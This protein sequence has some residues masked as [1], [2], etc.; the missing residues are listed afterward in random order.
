[1]RFRGA[2]LLALSL[3]SAGCSLHEVREEYPTGVDLP[4]SY[5]IRGDG[6]LSSGPWW[7]A[8]GD[9]RLSRTVTR[10][11]DGNPGLMQSWSRLRQ[12]EAIALQAESFLYPEITAR[13]GASRSRTS[14]ALGG[15]AGERDVTTSLFSLSAGVAYEVDLWKRL[16][17][18]RDAAATLALASREDVDALAMTLASQ[19]AET[20]FSIAEQKAQIDL[21]EEQQRIGLTFLELLELRFSLGQATALDVYQ[22]RQQVAATRAQFPLAESRLGVLRNQLA[23][24][25]GLAPGSLEDEP[26][27]ILPELPAVPD[28]GLPAEL[29]QRRPDVRGA[30]LRILAADHGVGEAVADLLPALRLSAEVGVQGRVLE[31]TFSNMIYQ[32][33]AGL[34]G[35]VYDRGRRRAEVERRKEILEE[36]LQGYR[37]K[38][39][40]ALGEVEDALVREDRQ[41]AYLLELAKQIDLSRSTLKQAG[42]RYGNG[43]SDYLPVL[44]ALQGL[45]QLERGEISSRR[46]L[47][48]HRIQLYRALG[49]AWTDDLSPPGSQSKVIINGERP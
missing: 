43:L 37:Q 45:Q 31:E 2:A 36:R 32:L 49:G 23:L 8:L 33:V 26:D 4:A 39:L 40:E 25:M 6:E 46:Q 35:P 42:L 18:R 30:E 19:V 10:V 28:I 5:S 3:L 22:Q 38:V 48:S 44:T 1:M 27:G 24:L 11:I 9:P 29:L 17:N 34:A 41:G 21:L 15:E 14:I 47:V 20:W 16:E 13:A 12:A 7:E